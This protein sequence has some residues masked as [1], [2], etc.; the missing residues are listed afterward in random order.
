MNIYKQWYRKLLNRRDKDAIN[1][2]N[3]IEKSG[4]ESCMAMC[5]KALA[6]AILKYSNEASAIIE[7]IGMEYCSSMA[8]AII[9]ETKMFIEVAG[10]NNPDTLFELAESALSLNQDS[11]IAKQY[12]GR[13]KAGDGHQ[14]EAISIFED[15][16]RSYPEV[17]WTIHMLVMILMMSKE[18]KKA[19]HYIPRIKSPVLRGMYKFYRF[20]IMYP[21]I[22]VIF[23]WPLSL[24]FA[25]ILSYKLTYI[26]L[27]DA[28]IV[29]G[30]G[31]IAWRKKDQYLVALSWRLGGTLILAGL[32]SLPL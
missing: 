8:R 29:L 25:L 24:F 20:I 28:F 26:Y 5:L 6:K 21:I 18:Y 31:I 3:E 7:K 16:A 11:F 19:G 14:E 1:V 23:L 15:I 32:L 12:I 27:W 9:L 13:T 22:P 30:F 4:D 10:E 17:D 2:L